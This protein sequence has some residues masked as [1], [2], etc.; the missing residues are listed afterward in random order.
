[1]NKQVRVILLVEANLEYERLNVIVGQ[2]FRE[3]KESTEE[4][5]L[6]RSIR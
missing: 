4:I 1:M 5:Q 3:G 2:Q 6:L